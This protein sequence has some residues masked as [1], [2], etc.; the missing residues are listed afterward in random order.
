MQIELYNKLKEHHDYYLDQ[1]RSNDVSGYFQKHICD[2][3]SHRPCTLKKAR[4]FILLQIV[5]RLWYWYTGKLP[6]WCYVKSKPKLNAVVY[7]IIQ[8]KEDLTI[9][10]Y[11]GFM[12]IKDKLKVLYEKKHPKKVSKKIK[13]EEIVNEIK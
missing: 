8:N 12:G 3:K 5:T 9:E 13:E 11:N 2:L 6:T 10:Q 7:Y 1:Y 4:A